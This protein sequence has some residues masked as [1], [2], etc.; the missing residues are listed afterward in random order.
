M[1]SRLNVFPVTFELAEGVFGFVVFVLLDP[2]KPFARNILEPL[3][4]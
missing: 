2:E 3:S 4:S 1:S